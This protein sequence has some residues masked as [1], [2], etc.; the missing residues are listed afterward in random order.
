MPML[1][2]IFQ[3]NLERA[4]RIYLFLSMSVYG[5]GKLAGDQFF[6]RGEIPAEIGGKTL[7]QAT[8]HDIAWVF[9][10]YSLFY[11]WFIG[12]SQ[13]FTGLM[14]LFEKTKLFALASMIPIMLNII[15][16]DICYGVSPGPLM[17]AILYFIWT[18]VLI[19]LNR[20]RVRSTLRA[21]MG[22]PPISQE[23]PARAPVR[24]FT[25]VGI[26][27]GMAVLELCLFLFLHFNVRATKD[28]WFFKETLGSI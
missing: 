26:M 22:L 27:A 11:L 17:S 4:L 21:A 13:A 9:F 5:W 8:A 2:P 28:F 18:G 25:I 19:Y 24:P 1:S 14:M 15:I 20:Q 23:T 7:V 10:G 16:V 3:G 12:L 6:L